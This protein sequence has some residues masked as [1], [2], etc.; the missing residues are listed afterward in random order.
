MIAA[1]NAHAM[2]ELLLPIS[3]GISQIA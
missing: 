1:E 2:I 3:S